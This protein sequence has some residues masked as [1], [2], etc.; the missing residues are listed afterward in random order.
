MV[1]IWMVFVNLGEGTLLKAA[2]ER[3]FCC[4]SGTERDVLEVIQVSGP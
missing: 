2:A 3:D 1:N 4:I